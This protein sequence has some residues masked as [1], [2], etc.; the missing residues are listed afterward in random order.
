MVLI[1]AGCAKSENFTQDTGKSS[2]TYS[3]GYKTKS[4]MDST[5]DLNTSYSIAGYEVEYETMDGLF[6][7]EEFNTEEYSG[8][9]ENNFKAVKNHPMSTFSIDVDTASYSNIRRMI[10]SGGKVVPDAVRIEEMI[11]YFRYDYESPSGDVPFSVN[12]EIS[13]CPWN[14]DAKLMLIGLQAKDIDLADR[15]SSNLVFLLD[16]SGSMYSDDKLP[17]MQ[18]AFIMLTENLN[19]ND[20]ISIVT[21]A[22]SE[23]VVLEG[24]RGDETMK[25]VSAIEDLSA[26]GSTAGAAG[27]QRV[28]ELAEEYFIEDGN[29]RIILA[30]DGDLNVGITSEGELKRL[31][32][33]ERKKG[34]FLSVLGFGTGNIKDNKMETLADNGNGNYAYIDSILEAKKV[35]V[36]EMGGTLFTV[37]KDVKLQVEFNPA[38]IKGYRLIG[39]ENRLLNT[40]DFN[41]DTK[42]AG[43][44]GAGHRVTALYEIIETSSEQ[45]IAESDLKYQSDKELVNSNEWL[46]VNIR[47][48]E[49]KEDKS[50]LLSFP[51]DESDYTSTMPENL[52]F[53]SSVAAFGMLLRESKWKGDSS[54]DM[55]IDIVE[56]LDIS[57]DEYKDEFVSLVKRMKRIN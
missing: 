27:I 42:D 52:A 2:Y 11:N 51:V 34:V 38:Y 19:E 10:N 33:K 43:E 9:T 36:E 44:I 6:V 21:Y 46:T 13:E 1:A 14:K 50:Q 54:Y 7:D 29:N 17:L 48:K 39:Y 32:E 31:V 25:I 37:A 28:Y 20:R 3:D 35:L 30:T 4:D 5:I 23:R 16:V 40:E 55:I 47:Y 18:K 8:I 15:P 57:E 53:A 24:V 41:D 49:P 26:G 56:E 22:G 12:T 45:E